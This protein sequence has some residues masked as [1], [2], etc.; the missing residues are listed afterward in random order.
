MLM[1]RR[2]II[3]YILNNQPESI[4]V[5]MDKN[6]LSEAEARAHIAT[7]L[8]STTPANITDIRIIDVHRSTFS[9]GNDRDKTTNALP[10]HNFTLTKREAEAASPEAMAVCGEE[11]PGE[12]LEFLVADNVVPDR[13]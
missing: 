2:F 3:N 7:S 8:G 11:D 4:D 1:Q 10:E 6:F 13:K 9:N 12:G 5:Q